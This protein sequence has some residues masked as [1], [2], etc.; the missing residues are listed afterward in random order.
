MDDFAYVAKDEYMFENTDLLMV[1]GKNL[2]ILQ[3]VV[4]ILPYYESGQEKQTHKANNLSLKA[5]PNPFTNEIN[6]Q[7]KDIKPGNYT[8]SLVDY[9]GRLILRTSLYMANNAP[10]RLTVPTYLSKGLYM[11]QVANST[12]SKSIKVVKQ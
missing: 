9:T 1:G 12:V 3:D 8:V 4:P 10:A 6:L 7:A 2:Y 5:Q 11:V